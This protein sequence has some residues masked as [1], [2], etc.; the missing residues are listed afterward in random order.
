MENFMGGV[1]ND[2]VVDWR[3]VKTLYRDRIEP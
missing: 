3:E 2:D 1:L